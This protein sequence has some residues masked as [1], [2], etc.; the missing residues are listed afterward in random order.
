MKRSL[1]VLRTRI[2]SQESGFSLIEVVVALMIFAIISMSVAYAITNSL[3]MTRETRAREIAANLAEQEIDLDRSINDVFSVNDSSWT[4]VVNGTTYTVV[5]GT[6]WVSQS[7]N[8]T[9]CGS[10]GGTLQYKEVN[11]SVTWAGQSSATGTVRADTLIAPNSRINDPTLGT[12]IVAVKSSTGIGMAG[13]TVSIAPAAIPN[14]AVALTTA[15][16]AT[17]ND[18]CSY[19]LK[20]TPGNYTVTLSRANYV[21]DHQVASP[22][23]PV[24]VAAGGAASAPFSYDNGALFTLLYASNYT[25]TTPLLPTNLAT[26]FVSTGG[27]VTSISVGSSSIRLFPTT[28]GYVTLAGGY[29]PPAGTSPTCL[30][31]DPA[32]WTTPNSGGVVGAP[33]QTVPATVGGVGTARIPMGVVKVSGLTVNNYLTAVTNTTNPGTNDPGCSVAM[34]YTFAKLTTT[35]VTVALPFGTWNLYT[36]TTS[37]STSSPIATTSLALQTPGTTNPSL[38]TITLDP[39][40]VTP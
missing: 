40:G 32:E 7:G 33:V 38:K 30:D 35:S 36:G 12:I 22:S 4:T 20:V 25:T 24:Q 28:N 10:A 8:G 23:V 15:P 18:G 21:D 11:V 39:R 3:V 29:V 19:A 31:V 37:G 34:T 13:V 6:N 14:G 17:D 2:A 26:T 5:R 27:G 1:F 16:A 9:A